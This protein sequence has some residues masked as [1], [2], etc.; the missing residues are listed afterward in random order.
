MESRRRVTALAL[1]LALGVPGA[2]AQAAVLN[3]GDLLTIDAGVQLYDAYG[4]PAG[5]S[6]GSWFALD[7]DSNRSIA[8]HEK[9]AI[10]P[11]TD[12]GIRIGSVQ[13]I[14]AID[15]WPDYFGATGYDYTTV[16]PTGGT[17]A[18]IDFSGWSI[19]WNGQPV[20]IAVDYGAWTPTNCATL[21]CAGVSFIADVAAFSW[22]GVYGD[23][24]TLWYSLS[25]MTDPGTW[26]TTDYILY[27]EGTVQAP[28]PVPAAVWLFGSGLIGLLGIVRRR[29]ADDRTH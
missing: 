21:G 10:Y 5:V 24:Y 11:G 12:G 13:A 1:G 23:S 2:G 18:G 6:G 3:A 19:Y 29:A 4:N 14:G 27:L 16:A 22:S 7:T 9:A 20:P 8:T 17:T 28:V 15:I 25:F 26:V